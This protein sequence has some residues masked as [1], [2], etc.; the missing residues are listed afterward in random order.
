MSTG[1]I[2]TPPAVS[3]AQNQV[4]LGLALDRQR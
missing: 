3:S 2:A 4:V 1:A